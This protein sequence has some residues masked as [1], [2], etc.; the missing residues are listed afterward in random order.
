MFV[1]PVRA[2]CSKQMAQ[3]QPEMLAACRDSVEAGRV[4]ILTFTRLE[5]TSFRH[6]T[7]DF[8]RP[9]PDGEDPDRRGRDLRDRLE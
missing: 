8:D 6:G 7:L 9:R 1:F 3:F 5:E 2:S 4:A